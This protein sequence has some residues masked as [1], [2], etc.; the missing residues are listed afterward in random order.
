VNSRAGLC[1]AVVTQLVAILTIRSR[2][3]ALRS[4]AEPA[5]T[6]AELG[7]GRGSAW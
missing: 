2:F 6:R 5:K 4:L 1:V 7:P 3:G